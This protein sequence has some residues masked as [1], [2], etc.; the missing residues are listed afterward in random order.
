M[1]VDPSPDAAARSAG[2]YSGTAQ[3]FHW[4]TAALMFTVLP[5]AWV[6]VNMPETAHARDTLFTLHKSVGVTILTLVAV[7]LAWRAGHP[8]P[9]LPNGLA[10]WVKKAALVSHWMLY[11]I[12]VGMPVSGYLMEAA[13]GYPISYFGLFSVPG[14]PKWPAL[15]DAAGWLHVAIGQWLVYALILLHVAASVW[16]VAVRRDGVLDR[17]LP[18]Q[19]SGRG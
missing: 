14:L 4:L 19:D 8:A 18:Q 2:R 7:R 9:P 16:H 13:G 17:M 11:A 5:L 12:L 6:M 15:S 3:A 10:R 1:N